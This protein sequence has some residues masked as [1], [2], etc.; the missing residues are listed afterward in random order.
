M[1]YN[2]EHCHAIFSS[3]RVDLQI[4]RVAH[5]E[6]GGVLYFRIFFL[7]CF[8]STY[9][10]Y[11]RR[12]SYIACRCPP[13][14]RECGDRRGSLSCVLLLC[15]ISCPNNQAQIAKTWTNIEK[16][17]SDLNK[18]ITKYT[19]SCSG[20]LLAFLFSSVFF[21]CH[22]LRNDLDRLIYKFALQ[23]F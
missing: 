9:N 11:R 13:C 21:V 18:R 1:Q 3:F 8:G 5:P 16:A 2:S 23:F 17:K 10:F 14:R 22:F 15:D 20:C 12:T 7:P 4:S 6:S 19:V